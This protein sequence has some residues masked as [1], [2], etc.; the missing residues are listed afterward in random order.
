MPSGIRLW[1]CDPG[2]EGGSTGRVVRPAEGWRL[3]AGAF[4]VADAD[5]A[6]GAAIAAGPAAAAAA[7]V[8]T[9]EDDDGGDG[10]NAVV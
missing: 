3:R 1:C 8:V 9:V 10:G 5:V 7:A 6:A 2:T 4:V